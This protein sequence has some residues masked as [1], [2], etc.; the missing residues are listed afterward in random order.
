MWA[1]RD[2]IWYGTSG[3]GFGGGMVNKVRHF[4][5]S[6]IAR[7][8]IYGIYWAQLFHVELGYQISKAK[9]QYSILILTLWCDVQILCNKL[10]ILLLNICRMYKSIVQKSLGNLD[11]HLSRPL[12]VK[13]DDAVYIPNAIS[14]LW[15][16]LTLLPI[17]TSLSLLSDLE[18]VFSGSLTFEI[19]CHGAIGTPIYDSAV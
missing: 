18:L 5:I 14:F 19:K 4:C 17:F 1:Y 12:K 13:A 3:L 9:L 8:L 6:V 2:D 10:N 15:L 16:A 11:A 7:V